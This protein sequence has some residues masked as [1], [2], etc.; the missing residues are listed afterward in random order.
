MPYELAASVISVG[1]AVRFFFMKKPSVASKAA[2]AV[3]VGASLMIWWRYPEWMV[4]ATLLQV[5][6]SIYIMMYLKVN[7]YA[8]WL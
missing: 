5:G 8:W 7:P 4:A 1:L 2:V 3:V 6:A